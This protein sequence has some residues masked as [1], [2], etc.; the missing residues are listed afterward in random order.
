MV[1]Q[2]GGM[3]RLLH[4][5]RVRL[6]HLRQ[7]GWAR[8]RES[9]SPRSSSSAAGR[10]GTERRSRPRR[11]RPRSPPSS[12]R[13]A[14]DTASGGGVGTAEERRGRATQPVTDATLSGAPGVPLPYLQIAIGVG[15]NRHHAKPGRLDTR[16]ERWGRGSVGSDSRSLRRSRLGDR[17]ARI[18]S[19]RSTAA[20]VAQTTWLR[21]V[22]NL[23]RIQRS[24]APRRLA[25]DDRTA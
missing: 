1:L 15:H 23:D 13:T 14:R 25:G 5:R 20:D 11:S 16:R 21:L 2:L 18:G 7:L 4:S 10:G 19:R 22:E 9:R 12:S 3:V 24:R 8:W 17:A 6:L